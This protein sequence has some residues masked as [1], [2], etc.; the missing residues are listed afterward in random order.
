MCVQDL[1]PPAR[2][3]MMRPLFRGLVLRRGEAGQL[4]GVLGFLLHDICFTRTPS[5]FQRQERLF[6]PNLFFKPQ[7]S[8][9][10]ERSTPPIRLGDSADW[11]RP[12]VR[13]NKYGR[14]RCW[15]G[16]TQVPQDMPSVHFANTATAIKKQYYRMCLRRENVHHARANFISRVTSSTIS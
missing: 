13:S 12:G 9:M 7:M 10:K 1:P 5:L 4:R 2:L 15:F 16:R 3:K 11:P 6:P 8:P 14:S